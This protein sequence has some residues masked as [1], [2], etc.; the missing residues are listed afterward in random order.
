MAL[1]KVVDENGTLVKTDV[2][3]LLKVKELSTVVVQGRAQ[4]DDAD[5]L[6]IL[7]TG[8]YVKSPESREESLEKGR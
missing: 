8:V 3:S 2:K 7:A 5:N 1:V 6:T 4:R